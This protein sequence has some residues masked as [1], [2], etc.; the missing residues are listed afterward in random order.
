V[1]ELSAKRHDNSS[2]IRCTC[3]FFT[4]E[5]EP[6]ARN[7][8]KFKTHDDTSG[9]AGRAG[10]TPSRRA[11]QRQQQADKP[12][13]SATS[14]HPAGREDAYKAQGSQQAG[15]AEADMRHQDALLEDITASLGSL[16]A[17]GQAMA[18]SNDGVDDLLQSVETAQQGVKAN[19]RTA[20]RF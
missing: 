12:A 15:Q 14:Q 18:D 20:R 16:A 3:S 4:P 8:Q 1:R 9:S 7:S 6:I 17:S 5:P 19:A 2:L 11:T 13:A 10:A